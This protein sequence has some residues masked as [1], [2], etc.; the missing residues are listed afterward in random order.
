[1]TDMD[2]VLDVAQ[3]AWPD[4]PVSFMS[5]FRDSFLTYGLATCRG[6][7]LTGLILLGTGLGTGM[8][9]RPAAAVCA[10]GSR[11]HDLRHLSRLLSALIFSPYQ[12]YP[13]PNRVKAD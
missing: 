13:A 11:L 12:C 3:R 9:T 2:T 6:G 10:G 4:A 1:M 7:E 8:L 5:H